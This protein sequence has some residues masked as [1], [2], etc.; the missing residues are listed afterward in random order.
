MTI[1]EDSIEKAGRLIA[2]RDYP[3]YELDRGLTRE[4][5]EAA[6]PG[7]RSAFMLI[8]VNEWLDHARTTGIPEDLAEAIAKVFRTFAYREDG[9]AQIAAMDPKAPDIRCNKPLMDGRNEIRC[10]LPLNHDGEC[11]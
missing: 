3:H 5:L 4:V 10:W 8:S 1:P 7:I 9:R 6:A 2:Q 11:R